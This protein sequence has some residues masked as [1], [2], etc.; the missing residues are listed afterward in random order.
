[1]NLFNYLSDQHP[2]APINPPLPSYARSYSSEGNLVNL[3][4]E[5]DARFLFDRF[6]RSGTNAQEQEAAFDYVVEHRQLD[7]SQ[8]RAILHSLRRQVSLVNG[9]PGTGKSFFASTLGDIITR[10]SKTFPTGPIL[11][12][13]QTNATVDK[14]AEFFLDAGMHISRIGMSGKSARVRTYGLNRQMR[15]FEIAYPAKRQ[16]RVKEEE[17]KREVERRSIFISESHASL[18]KIGTASHLWHHLLVSNPTDCEKVF[19][20]GVHTEATALVKLQAWIADG[21]PTAPAQNYCTDRRWLYTKSLANLNQH[22]RQCLVAFWRNDMHDQVFKQLSTQLQLADIAHNAWEDHLN[23]RKALLLQQCDVITMT[24]T[25]AA[26]HVN[27]IDKVNPVLVIMEEAARMSEL[28]SIAS[29]PAFC[30]HLILIGD[31]HQNRP[32]VQDI[33][34]EYDRGGE[35]SAYALDVSVFERAVNPELS[36]KLFSI[37]LTSTRLRVN[38][39]Y[40][41]DLSV[42]PRSIFYPDL[43]DAEVTKAIPF[44][45]WL[46]SRFFMWKEVIW[47]EERVGMSMINSGEAQMVK[48]ALLF[49]TKLQDPGRI[50]VITGI[51]QRRIRASESHD[52][53]SNPPPF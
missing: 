1:M 36:S 53:L 44:S 9:P 16:W 25:G 28:H 26:M 42:L 10:T 52:R 23:E 50:A 3:A 35:A 15:A 14:G 5:S 46:A 22:Q 21:Q 34:F 47:P 51:S 38:R 12:V 17:L 8:A 29:I 49:I 6:D 41:P 45:A 2:T 18:H 32:M 20:V 19:G 11:F 24:T 43:E 31:Q 7:V 4:R 39:R 33:R 27:L 30:D 13:A 37:T 48:N 40:H